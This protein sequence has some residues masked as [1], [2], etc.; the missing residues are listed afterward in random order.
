MAS[1]R[2]KKGK[3][4]RS[5]WHVA[6][7]KKDF[8][9]CKSF[10]C[11]EDAELYVIYKERL[12]DNISNFEVPIHQRLRL[13]D[14]YSMKIEKENITDPKTL[15]DYKNS[16]FRLQSFLGENT[17]LCNISPIQ[18]INCA[19]ELFKMDVFRGAKTET[20]RRPM[21]PITLKRIFAYASACFSYAQSK[22]IE[23]DNHALKVIQCYI[24][25]MINERGE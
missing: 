4:G 20:G 8:E 11:K 5:S 21:S 17:F 13:S 2:E 24:T 19:K 6:I 9:I 7:R 1:I 12:I 25:P 22:G 23:I 18:W 15:N 14:I 10:H 16:L 3:D